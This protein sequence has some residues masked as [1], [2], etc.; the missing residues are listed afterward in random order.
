MVKS[1]RCLLAATIASLCVPVT[2]SAIQPTG[3][4]AEYV[5]INEDALKSITRSDDIPGPW[6][7]PEDGIRKW[8]SKS[9]KNIAPLLW[10]IADG[11]TE[12]KVC[13]AV[14]TD[15]GSVYISRM[16]NNILGTY[17]IKGTLNENGNRITIEFPQRM[18]HV[19]NDMPL[20][21]YCM[22][23]D[24]YDEDGWITGCTVNENQ[25][26]TMDIL[27]DGTILPTEENESVVIGFA[28]DG[29]FMGYGDYQY[30][31]EPQNDVANTAPEGLE[32][33]L[34]AWR[35]HGED[36]FGM[37]GN[38]AYIGF[39]GDEVWLK[40]TYARM[41]EAWLKGKK[42]ENG[43][44][45]ESNQLLGAFDPLEASPYWL[46]TYGVR[47]TEMPSEE[48][49]WEKLYSLEITKE[50]N[51]T[52]S[53]DATVGEEYISDN[54]L[55]FWHNL[56]DVD[57]F[58]TP[59]FVLYSALANSP[60]ISINDELGKPATPEKPIKLDFSVWEDGTTYLHYAI[61]QLSTD[62]NL[63]DPDKLFY[64]VYVDGS[65]YTFMP[66]RYPGVPEEGLSLVPYRFSAQGD[67][68]LTSAWT[69]NSAN[70][71]VMIFTPVVESL[72][73]KSVYITDD[74]RNESEMLVVEVSGISDIESEKRVS[75]SEYFDF[76]GKRVA[77]PGKG[78]YLRKVTYTDGSSDTFKEI[79]K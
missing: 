3:H 15:D 79:V 7:V 60:T 32:T 26:Y 38:Y 19:G 12:G 67:G 41:P 4:K 74:V 46:Y 10:F 68:V 72:G 24:G 42:T 75:R 37:T 11:Q 36:T 69:E 1:Y 25:T 14:F 30:V 71:D 40:G 31:I 63:L 77:N 58:Q 64:E 54:D 56:N 9:S 29:E 51:F 48:D 44:S 52:L 18:G 62:G 39:N 55:L 13:D 45:F 61:P 59:E 27:E 33:K 78:L 6:D 8:Y 43:F 73:V 34:C 57:K 28:I 2:A 21:F 65:L 20:D 35:S 66:D 16:V 50:I 70:H 49:E 53:P 5:R 23:I 17:Y 76:T 47:A 22:T